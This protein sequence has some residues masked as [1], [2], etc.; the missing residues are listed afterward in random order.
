[1]TSLLGRISE[2][3]KIQSGGEAVVYRAKLDGNILVALKSYKEIRPLNADLLSFFSSHQFP[4]VVK[5]F[6]A[7]LFKG[8]PFTI[9]EYIRSVSSLDMSP[10][11]PLVAVRLLREITVSVSA[12]YA[13][14]SFHGDLSPENVLIKDYSSPYLVDC[15]IKG[16][17][18]PHFAAPERFQGA[19]PSAKS[20][21]FSLGA[22]LYFWLTGEPLCG[23]S[24]FEAIETSVFK[25]ESLDVTLLLHGKGRL[26]PE[27]LNALDPLWQGL[28]RR[29]PENR[30]EDFEE[31]DERL[32]IAEK[33]IASE[34]AEKD[35]EE[36]E[37]WKAELKSKIVER[38]TR[39]DASPEEFPFGKRC[40]T[41][42]FVRDRFARWMLVCLFG[43][44]LIVSVLVVIFLIN[45]QPQVED[46]GKS[47]LESSR[48]LQM[49]EE[50]RSVNSEKASG[51]IMGIIS[52]EDSLSEDEERKEIK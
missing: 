5:L 34:Q 52:D 29:L 47:M 27:V 21:L 10:M 31:L 1:V 51:S 13:A 26:R 46:V 16:M 24:T 18:T 38:E 35:L 8:R 20:E 19:G 6:G 49:E 25:V 37:F 15:G 28:L 39:I 50:P 30:F 12:L 2:C 45:D 41:K 23:G 43:L 40:G 44:V 3:H 48:H 22:V 4:N 14:G 42:S 33:C 36:Q 7:D 9:S 32:E 11:P 17:G